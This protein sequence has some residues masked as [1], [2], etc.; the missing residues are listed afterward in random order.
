M[1]NKKNRKL[2]NENEESLLPRTQVIETTDF[3]L[4]Y[5]LAPGQSYLDQEKITELINEIK[6]RTLNRSI[7]RFPYDPIPSFINDEA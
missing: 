1:F 4:L 2:T 3:T 7:Q 5:H 6:A